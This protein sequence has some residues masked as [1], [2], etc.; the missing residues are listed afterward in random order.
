MELRSSTH[1][2]FVHAIKG[3]SVVKSINVDTRGRPAVKFKEIK[4]IYNLRDATYHNQVP[5]ICLR[6]D[7]ESSPAKCYVVKVES[8]DSS[9]VRGMKIK[10]EPEDSDFNCRNDGGERNDE[11]DDLSLGNMTL[12]QIKK[13]CKTKKRKLFNSVGLNKEP[14]ETC[15]SV[16]HEFPNFQREDDDYDLEEP[17]INW[18]SKLSTIMRGKRKCL[19]KNVS[20]SSS[21]PMSIIKSEQVNSDEDLMHSNGDLPAPIVV[22]TYSSVTFVSD[23]RCSERVDSIVTASNEVPEITN[24][25][26]LET[27]VPYPTE[28]SQYCSLNEVPYKYMG[29]FEPKF[30]VG[31]SSWEI[32][33]I[34]NPEIIS[35]E[36]SELSESKKENYI[37]NQFNPLPYDVSSEPISQKEDY[38][39]DIHGNFQSNSTEHEIPGQISSYSLIQ[40]PEKT[41]ALHLETGV[42]MYPI[43]KSPC[44]IEDVPNFGTGFSGWEIVKVDSPEIISYECS[45]LQE[46]EKE[47][48]AVYPLAYDISSESMSPSEDLSCDL[49]D[50]F[51]SNSSEHMMALQT[52]NYGPIEVPEMDSDNNPQCL[53]DINESSTCSFE[54]RTRHDWPSNIRNIVISSSS[55]NSLYSTPSCLSPEKNS[56]PVSGALPSAGKQS[57]SPASRA[58][59]SI[60]TSDKPM[61]SP[62]P[63]NYHQLNQNLYPERLLSSRKAISPTS[64]ERLCRAMELTALDDNVHR[65]CRGKLYFGKQTN[66]RILK[67]QGLNQF[68]IDGAT[69]KP[70]PI[71]I[72]EKQDKKWSPPKG[73]L[74]VTHPSRSVPHVSPACT[75]V[76]HC[77]QSAITFSQRQMLDIETLATRLTRELKSMKDIMKGKLQW[78]ASAATAAKENAEEVRIAIEKATKMEE[79]AIR[80]LSMMA[81]DC[82]R[83]C[84]IM[85]LTG[86]N[87]AASEHVIHKDK[88]ITFADEAGGKLCHVKVFK[89]DL[90]KASLLKCGRDC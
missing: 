2:H 68:R 63:Q 11:L 79:T 34:D 19:Q 61:A 60:E 22:N 53:E 83:F 10:S 5:T 18:K 30:N 15:S 28:E 32:V 84:E 8:S 23:F 80:W 33:K 6:D 4:E 58:T 71:M 87:A 82:N 20:A 46:F 47:G 40:V 64:Q 62:Q 65:K 29:N 89:D 59:S 67:A 70:Q 17:L 66:H 54:S 3:G 41:I 86:D 39:C 12:K 52:S 74:K 78:E 27:K 14:V 21:S 48:Y 56:I 69:I 37:I 31:V 57:L 51:K 7:M 45:D 38:S 88:K 42:S 13:R 55:V 76:Q 49:H 43:E 44:S 16:E 36:Y 26:F 1:L 50:G 85:R 24:V 25:H 72:K 75:T 73:I 81:R 35:Y 90:G 77:S 9:L